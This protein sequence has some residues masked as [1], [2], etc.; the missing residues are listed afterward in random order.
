MPLP[1]FP[2][3]A[4]A[5]AA[6]RRSSKITILSPT[7]G[8]AAMSD[9]GS[10][11]ADRFI[12]DAVRDADLFDGIL[13]KR[14]VAFVIDAVLIVAL[15]VPAAMIVG[16]F[17]IVTLGIG[18]LLFSPLF[19][20][21]ALGY[22]AL[23]LGGRG[24]ATFGMRIAGIEIRTWSGQRMFPLLAIL[25]AVIFWISVSVLT[26][27]ILLVGLFTARRQLLHDLLLGV[28]ALN[29]DALR[30]RRLTPLPFGFAPLGIMLARLMFPGS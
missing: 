8:R 27:L 14:I 29:S 5:S 6:L 10:R 4:V 1:V 2:A 7:G 16:I 26:P 9:S 28:V 23:T 15:M 17:G 18:W 30:R 22:V 21:V 19:A 13:S 25:H 12:Y 3:G 24:S 11:S 20:I